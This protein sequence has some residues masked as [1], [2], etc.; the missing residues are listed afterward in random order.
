LT[1][2]DEIPPPARS[3]TVPDLEPRPTQASKPMT[4]PPATDRPPTATAL[5]AA[6]GDLETKI[7]SQL[8]RQHEAQ[9]REIREGKNELL[10]RYQEIRADIRAIGDATGR[11][12]QEL[13]GVTHR[14][15]RWLERHDFELDALSRRVATFEKRLTDALIE[16]RASVHPGVEHDGSPPED[17]SR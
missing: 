11:D 13:Q 6:F 12:I 4:E 1:D 16:K 15:A 14:H 3:S 8:D 9:L 10:V 2:A 5:A 7:L 17:P